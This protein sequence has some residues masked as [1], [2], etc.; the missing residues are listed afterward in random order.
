MLSVNNGIKEIKS[1]LLTR[2][3]NNYALKNLKYPK[4]YLISEDWGEVYTTRV[5][6]GDIE[7]MF[8]KF[9]KISGLNDTYFIKS[10][11]NNK[12]ICASREFLEF[13]QLRKPLTLWSIQKYKNNELKFKNCQWTFDK[14]SKDENIY[15]IINKQYNTPLYS[16]G[17]VWTFTQM[18]KAYRQSF[19]WHGKSSKEDE[20]KWRVFLLV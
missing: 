18:G 14:I 7:K 2:N 20:F 17:F 6:T 15:K 9:E 19:V 16:P 12:Y 4:E 11:L 5:K 3:F 8:W 1:Q 10:A 13:S